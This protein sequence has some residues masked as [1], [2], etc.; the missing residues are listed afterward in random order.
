MFCLSLYWCLVL[1]IL[2]YAVLTSLL[3]FMNGGI[4]QQ[5]MYTILATQP[6]IIV[7][8]MSTKMSRLISHRL[9]VKAYGSPNFCE[10]LEHQLLYWNGHVTVDPQPSL[11]IVQNNIS[12]VNTYYL[13]FNFN[14]IFCFD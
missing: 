10:T 14:V 7:E 5:Q 13:I 2:F 12:H 4:P 1:W 3:V 9:Q 8:T 11:F 6:E